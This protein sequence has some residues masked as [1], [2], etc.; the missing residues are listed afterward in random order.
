MHHWPA[1]Q[2]SRV[3]LYEIK[4]ESFSKA[5]KFMFVSSIYNLLFHISFILNIWKPKS[6][7]KLSDIQIQCF[8]T[9]CDKGDK[10]D[11]FFRMPE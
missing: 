11:W 10:G 5:F 7:R 8:V 3:L 6:L 1:K 2:I 4:T 9:S